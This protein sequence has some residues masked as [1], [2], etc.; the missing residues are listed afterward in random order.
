MAEW[1]NDDV[2]VRHL[3]INLM[4]RCQWDDSVSKMLM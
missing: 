1:L 4:M 3:E 2:I